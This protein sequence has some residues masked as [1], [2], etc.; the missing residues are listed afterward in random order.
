LVRGSRAADNAGGG[1][2]MR[3]LLLGAIFATLA[4]APVKAQTGRR[5][6]GEGTDYFRY[7]LKQNG[8]VSI[9]DADAL[10]DNSD[11]KALI[12]FGRTETLDQLTLDHVLRTFLEHGGRVLIATDRRTSDA[13]FKEIGVQIAGD[14]WEMPEGNPHAI[15]RQSLAQCPLI[16]D[17]GRSRTKRP[18]AP[19]FG[20]AV[21]DTGSPVTNIATNLPS[22]I[23]PT[24]RYLPVATLVRPG[25]SFSLGSGRRVD[26][27]VMLGALSVNWKGNLL[28]LA[29][30]SI[31]INDMMC[32]A[33]NDNAPFANNIV[34]WLMDAGAGDRREEVLF[35]DDGRIQTEFNVS[36]A[37]P[38]PASVPLEAL[39]PLADE[40]LVELERENAFNAMLLDATGGPR[41][42]LRTVALL[43]T[44]A[45]L[46]FGT[47]RFLQSRTRPE[48]RVPRLAVAPGAS[49][50]AVTAVE[51]RHRAVIAQGNLAEAARE[52]AH[53]AFA[54]IGLTPLPD[55]P[56][57]VVSVAG[58]WP[59]FRAR[60]WGRVVGDVWILAA[61]GPVRR[62][63]P[64][65]LRRLD[66]S[67]HGLLAAVAAGEVRLAAGDSPI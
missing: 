26:N 14:T 21:S 29:D 36:L 31:F 22:W 50:A 67:L 45:L 61:R 9:K 37:T 60:R 1:W 63:S 19:F 56:P 47:Y 39:V 34:H 13:V 52:L 28:V 24:S 3:A 33:D 4:A 40:T 54:A 25:Y 38:P 27:Q 8:A 65:A 42:I 48:A 15:Y 35:Y 18:T 62:I 32:Q 11:R 30:H 55:A 59:P 53:Q 58:W 5:R 20:G 10:L 64:A 44:I 16:V 41:P 7:V 46:L 66:A 6:F 17:Y 49:A 23:A 2:M 51:R 12:V 57:P 43:L